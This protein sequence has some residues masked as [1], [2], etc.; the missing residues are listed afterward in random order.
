LEEI[1]REEINTELILPK[2]FVKRGRR[3]KERVS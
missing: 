3:R 1:V 2:D